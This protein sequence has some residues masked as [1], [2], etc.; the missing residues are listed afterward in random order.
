M[1]NISLKATKRTE[2]SK[3]S[4]KKFRKV[5]QIP[6]VLYGQDHENINFFIS[7]KELRN[8]IYTNKV[9][10]IDLD[11]DGQVYKCIKKETQF[12]PVTDKILHIDL[13]KI[14]E[15]KP[16]KIFVPVKL[17]G[18]AKGVQSGG[19]LYK[20]KR[21]LKLKALMQFIPDELEID[22]TDLELGK[23]IK[24]SDIKLENI[25]ILEPTSDVIASVKL[26]RAAMSESKEAEGEG[27]VEGEKI[28]ETKEENK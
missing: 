24:V 9:Y 22:V 12:H 1:K 17:H 21:Y 14:N 7:E 28:E 8:L 23:S 18:F 4:N 10:F 25:E 11:I 15:D 2:I 3:K 13:I 5:G 16:V 6:G 27:V 26:T 19:N 20:M